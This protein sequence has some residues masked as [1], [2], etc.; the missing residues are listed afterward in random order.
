MSLVE[1][2]ILTPYS[3]S[4]GL[5]T[6]GIGVTFRDNIDDI[7]AK[8]GLPEQ[9]ADLSLQQDEQ[10]FIDQIRQVANQTYTPGAAGTFLLRTQL[11]NIMFTR[12]MT[13]LGLPGSRQ[14]AFTITAPQ[15]KDLF[16][17]VARKYENIIDGVFPGTDGPFNKGS[18]PDSMERAALFSLVYSVGSLGRKL[19]ADLKSGDRADA[20]FEIRYD[21]NGGT[22]GPTNGAARAR[23]IQSQVFGL[24]EDD[25]NMSAEQKD[26]EYKNIFAMYT[27][28][29]AILVGY[30]QQFGKIINQM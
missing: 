18:I 26:A 4:K 5:A 30:D 1:D 14:E 10:D 3:D 6:I 13:Y 8:L 28:H 29:E 25:T 9:F 21:T 11:D 19:T 17:A 2:D 23:Y 24:Y 12:F 27:S 15:S 20:W 7:L 22:K 16:A